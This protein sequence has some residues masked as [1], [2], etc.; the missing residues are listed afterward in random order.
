[1]VTKKCINYHLTCVSQSFSHVYSSK[2][3]SNL[4]NCGTYMIWEERLY[5]LTETCFA[6][7]HLRDSQRYFSH[8]L[9]LGARRIILVFLT[10]LCSLLSHWIHQM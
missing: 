6:L 7:F 4:S 1:M 5:L 2:T 10:D 3:P 8:F 9:N